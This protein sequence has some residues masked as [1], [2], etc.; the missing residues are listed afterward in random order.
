MAFFSAYLDTLFSH[1]T[2]SVSSTFQDMHITRSHWCFY[3]KKQW[4]ATFV[5]VSFEFYFFVRQIHGCTQKTLFVAGTK[6]LLIYQN[7]LSYIKTQYLM[8]LSW[9]QLITLNKTVAYLIDT[10]ASSIGEVYH[11]WVYYKIKP[12]KDNDPAAILI[13]LNF[14]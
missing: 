2:Q 8:Y 1:S 9:D 6:H 14:L 3:I 13:L 10:V 4:F 7:S 11:M 5:C 12:K